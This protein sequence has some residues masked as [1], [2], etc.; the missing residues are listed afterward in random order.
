MAGRRSWTSE[1]KIQIALAIESGQ[2]TR[3]QAASHY[4][5]PYSTVTLWH[6]KFQAEGV[7]AFYAGR[8]KRG[9]R[10]RRQII[11][12]LNTFFE[13]CGVEAKILV[14]LHQILRESAA[15]YSPEA[16][17]EEESA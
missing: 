4:G 11:A 14:R 17:D 3:A 8:S 12:D 6:K 5:I 7:E 2:M 9:R 1:E 16:P 13:N 10:T 15:P